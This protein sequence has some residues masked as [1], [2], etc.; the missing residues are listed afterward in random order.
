MR[1][2][3]NIEHGTI[4][5]MN[6]K[7]L[8]NKALEMLETNVGI[9][10]TD[11]EYEVPVPN[12]Y[13][14]C[15]AELKINTQEFV[16]E[17][18]PFVTRTN[19]GA[20]VNQIKL[21]AE[22]KKPLLIT[23]YINPNLA[24]FLKNEDINFLDIVGNAYLKTEETFVL[25]KG[26]RA[27]KQAVAR[28]GSAFTQTG[29]KVIYAFLVKPE[30]LNA[31]YRDIAEA[32]NVALGNVGWIL[33]GLKDQQY[34]IEDLKTKERH[35]NN[36]TRPLLIDKWV[37]AYPKL[38]QKHFINRYTSN[39]HEWWKTADIEKYNGLMAGEIA[40]NKYTRYLKP[41]DHLVYI[42]KEKLNEFL[43][44]F[45]LGITTETNAHITIVDVVEKFWGP[46]LDV[47]TNNLT[48][49]LLTYADLIVSGDV[50]NREVAKKIRDEHL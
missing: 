38:K 36:E 31:P 41:Q 20:V 8:I 40:A 19:Y 9:V 43:K 6:K 32:A 10:A 29:L 42:R 24:D 47:D 27:P 12:T 26:N 30:L 14:C 4:L 34:I 45:R 22:Q 48:T 15:D 28:V 44:D 25:I 21:I 3:T 17:V 2:F 16:V 5:N 39:N 50:R 23:N 35:W 18:K 33:R 46:T 37:E 1:L 11:I 49:P 7:E 13:H